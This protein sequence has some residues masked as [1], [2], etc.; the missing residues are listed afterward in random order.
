MTS[1][2]LINI[3][4][5]NQQ[6]VINGVISYYDDDI[7][8]T[9]YNKQQIA[10]E[11][12]PESLRVM[13]TSEIPMRSYNII[14]VENIRDM[15]YK[16]NFTM[17]KSKVEP[18]ALYKLQDVIEDIYI[19]NKKVI[20]TMGKG[21][22]GKTSI[23]ATIALGLS[24]KGVKVHLATTDP[25]DHLRNVIEEQPFI[26]MSHI[27]EEDELMKYREIVLQKAME[28]N[29]SKEDI[30]YIEEDL[31]S[32]CTQ[33]IA[34]FRAF[35]N[36]V[37][38]S[39]EEVVI[40]DTAPTGHTLLLLDSTQSYYKEVKR[41]M[42][43]TDEAIR[44]LLPRLRDK[45][46]T[47][48]IITTLPESTPV[49][50]SLRLEENSVA[51]RRSECLSTFKYELNHLEVYMNTQ[52]GKNKIP[53]IKCI[54]KPKVAFLCV[55]NSCRSQIAEALGKKYAT[56]VFESYS[57]GT[58]LKDHINPDAVR[59][60]KKMHGI[61]MEKDQY[62]KLLFDIPTPDVIIL[63][64]CNVGCPNLPHQYLEDWG[65]ED[66][67]GKGDEEFEVII[68]MIEKRIKELR[69]KLAI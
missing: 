22:V 58:E 3:G 31:R 67:T 27:D 43:D 53:E 68:K 4:I 36:I 11:N 35:A 13:V 45:N 10:L 24:R 52:E 63:M 18:L 54:G 20:F 17:V 7:S 64:G 59:M 57:A 42:G 33:E 19:N 61:D 23:A 26:S 6:L 38:K 60:M 25:A 34:V 14:G 41:S 5:R 39:N 16:D 47:E 40:I 55:H 51:T 46:K 30:D 37:A 44:E 50:E 49:Y 1:K 65:L 9:Y 2:E 29:L 62:N 12:M 8:E 56:D 15:L 21:G 32:P 69:E 66:P 28:N 48:V